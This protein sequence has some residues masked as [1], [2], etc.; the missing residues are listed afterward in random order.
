MDCHRGTVYRYPDRAGA[1]V[2]FRI[3]QLGEKRCQAP[4]GCWASVSGALRGVL[5]VAAISFSTLYRV[6]KSEDWSNTVD[7]SSVLSDGFDYLQSRLLLPRAGALEMWLNEEKHTCGI[8]GIAG[9]M[10]L[11]SRFM[12]P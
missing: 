5:I 6:S 7:P 2:N 9:V 10:P 11:T 1:I 12:M 8:V 3:G 4:I